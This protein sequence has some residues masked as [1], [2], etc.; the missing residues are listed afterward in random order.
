MPSLFESRSTEQD[1]NQLG[2]ILSMFKTLGT[3]SEASWPE[4]V[5]WKTNPFGFWNVFEGRAWDDI[6]EG[7][8]PWGA[9]LVRRCVVFESGQRITAEEVSCC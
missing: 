8:V 3:P 2:L 5:T 6:L 4:A 1:G 9:E 7:V